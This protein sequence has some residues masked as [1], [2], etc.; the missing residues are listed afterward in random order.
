MRI[1]AL[2]L[3]LLLGLFGGCA[4]MDT[5]ARQRQV[6][7]VVAYLF[8]GSETP[9][10]VADTVAELK[11]PFRIG[12]AFVPD[13][14]SPEFRLPENDR[15]KLASQVSEAFSNYPFVREIVA[16]PSM[17]LDA[18]G[19][20]GNLDR[21]AAMLNLNVVALISFDQVQNAG[22]N[23]WSF[24]YWTGVGAYVVDG[25]QY[26][27]LTSVETTVF[28]IKSSRLLMRGGGISNL[29]GTATMVG[30]SE[31]ARAARSRG[32]DAAVKEMIS[33]LQAEV[34]SFRERAPKDPMIR[35]VL[36][37]DYSA[38]AVIR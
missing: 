37:P 22:A 1:T 21:I 36:P 14:A 23:G 4:S 8:P 3:A 11:V 27:I 35:L 15:I 16:V 9:S 12:V 38:A 19:G 13:T 7:S 32:F 24:L 5:A 33:N 10:I 26:D 29:K 25:D 34:K 2:L 17:Y 18:G 6:G 31:Q 20:F 28:D 30:F